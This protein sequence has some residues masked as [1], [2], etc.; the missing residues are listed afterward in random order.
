MRVEGRQSWVW[1]LTVQGVG[2]RVDRDLGRT[3]HFRVRDTFHFRVRDTFHF[4][5]RD[6]GFR[7]QGVGLIGSWVFQFRIQVWD[8]GFRV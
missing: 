8:S 4:R 5:V 2:C 6:L 1:G 3:F 7:V